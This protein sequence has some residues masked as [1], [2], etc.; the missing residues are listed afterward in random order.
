MNH[1]LAE[2]NDLGGAVVAII[3]IGGW[4]VSAIANA[5]K[6][7]DARRPIGS[8]PPPSTALE[9]LQREIALRLQG[10]QPPQLPEAQRPPA[11]PVAG[12][13]QIA[14]RQRML[15]LQRQAV[16]QA[17]RLKAR[18]SRKTPPLAPPPLTRS[19]EPAPVETLVPIEAVPPPSVRPQAPAVNAVALSRWM[20]PATLRQQFIITEIFQPPL[21]MRE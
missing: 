20:T 15:A 12:N 19:Q 17:K 16:Q 7:S 4:I 9:A 21:S 18:P 11:L 8:A 2:G 3:V 1:F 6:R 10:V 5:K 13:P 14:A